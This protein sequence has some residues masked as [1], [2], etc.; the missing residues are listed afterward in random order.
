MFEIFLIPLPCI[1]RLEKSLMLCLSF[2]VRVPGAELFLACASEYMPFGFRFLF[3]D[4]K[5]FDL[6]G[7]SKGRGIL[8]PILRVVYGCVTSLSLNRFPFSGW[9]S[10]NFVFSY[11]IDLWLV[12]ERCKSQWDKTS[13][14]SIC[15]TFIL[16]IWLPFHVLRYH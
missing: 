16:I 1:L 7:L 11:E 12:L 5:L 6:C 13:N 15:N 2:R 3:K 4:L 9:S 10:S 14:I 8:D